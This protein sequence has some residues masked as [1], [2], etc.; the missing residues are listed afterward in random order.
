MCPSMRKCLCVRK[1]NNLTFFFNNMFVP[2]ILGLKFQDLHVNELTCV[3][4]FFLFFFFTPINSPLMY[5][6]MTDRAFRSVQSS[7]ER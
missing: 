2:E 4:F 7:I 1:T 5:L 6:S 3:Y